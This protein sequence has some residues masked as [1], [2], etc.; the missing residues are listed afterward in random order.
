[1]E[2]LPILRSYD[3][4]RSGSDNTLK[5][6][7]VVA[8]LDQET[9]A[10]LQKR[11]PLGR[12]VATKPGRDGIARRYVVRVKGKEYERAINQLSLVLR[13]DQAYLQPDSNG[14]ANGSKQIG[15]LNG[16]G[17]RRRA[18]PAKRVYFIA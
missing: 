9:A 1:M 15:T 4:W 14:K 7:D 3:K 18:Q 6:D 2:I 17:R 5:V 8:V 13:E 11:F 16:K 10:A 12:I